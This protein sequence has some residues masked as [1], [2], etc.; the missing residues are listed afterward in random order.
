VCKFDLNSR[1]SNFANILFTTN[2][3]KNCCGIEK[4]LETLSYKAAAV[5]N[6]TNILR[7]AFVPI[8]FPQTIT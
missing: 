6:F 8:F 3:N 7:A 1:K 5:V 4:I 2:A